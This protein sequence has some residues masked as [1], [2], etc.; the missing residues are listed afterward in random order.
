MARPL[1][2]TTLSL[3]PQVASLPQRRL[4]ELASRLSR[5]L[6][7]ARALAQSGRRVDLAGIEDGVGILCAQ[8]LDLETED[9]Q[10]ML[11][12]LREVMSQI[13]LLASALSQAREQRGFE[14]RA[15]C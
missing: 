2:Q 5:T 11:P 12:V 14:P 10:I 3:S 6:G 13:E 7:V 4:T 1:P 15:S 9:G 8:T